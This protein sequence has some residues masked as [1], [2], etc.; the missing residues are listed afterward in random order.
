MIKKKTFCIPLLLSL[1]A[2]SLCIQRNLQNYFLSTCLTFPFIISWLATTQ[3][4]LKAAIHGL[5]SYHDRLFHSYCSNHIER[6]P[7]SHQVN[8][9]DGPGNLG[10]RPY[11]I[12]GE[13]YMW[14]FFRRLSR[15]NYPV[16][17]P[18][19]QDAQDSYGVHAAGFTSLL[20][21]KEEAPAHAGVQRPGTVFGSFRT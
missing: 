5:R 17:I 2:L 20:H 15:E 21:M 9:W 16:L 10:R 11:S 8:G 3:L 7:I 13:I 14:K 19:A 1:Q 6:F 4:P 18:P 12:V